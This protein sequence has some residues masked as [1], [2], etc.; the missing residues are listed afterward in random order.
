MKKEEVLKIVK[1]LNNKFG[2]G[3]VTT[4][5]KSKKVERWSTGIPE[6]DHITGGGMPKG[7]IIELYGPESSGKTSLGYHLCAQVPLSV[8]IPIEGTF[9]IKRCQQFGNTNKNLLKVNA[10]YGEQAIKAIKEF[11]KKNVPLI[12]VDSVPAM[13]TK[14]SMENKNPEKED[15]RAD[16]AGMLAREL[17]KVV[18]DLEDRGTT[19]I[20]INQERDNMNGGFFSKARTPGGRAL[21]FYASLRIRTMRRSWVKVPNK[22]PNDSANQK[23]I[24]IKQKFRI[25]KSK[26]CNPYMEAEIYLLFDRGYIKTKNYKKIRKKIMKE[27]RKKYK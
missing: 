16:V 7:R 3:T 23:R 17:P 6:L 22:D 21:K 19:V 9:D 24:G 25:E 4:M 12:V 11:S 8:Y 15:R 14:E 1:K 2:D 26:V 5:D 18:K 20:F 10:D 27:N 13:K